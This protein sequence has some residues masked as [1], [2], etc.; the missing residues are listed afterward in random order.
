M[1][2]SKQNVRN[3]KYAVYSIHLYRIY[4]F[5]K[6]LLK[7]SLTPGNYMHM[8][9]LFCQMRSRSVEAWI[10]LQAV[11]VFIYIQD[12]SFPGLFP[13]IDVI[14]LWAMKTLQLIVA[15]ITEDCYQNADWKQVVTSHPIKM[16]SLPFLQ[17]VCYDPEQACSNLISSAIVY[18]DCSIQGM[19]HWW[20]DSDTCL[21][22]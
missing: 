1:R 14:R 3:R 10:Y 16:T 11:V 4:S 15:F 21:L 18:T 17:T 22:S 12:T 20:E 13:C 2:G 9:I 8:T 19:I 7:Q 5:K 6:C